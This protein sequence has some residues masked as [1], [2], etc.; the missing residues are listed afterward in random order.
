MRNLEALGKEVSLLSLGSD[1]QNPEPERVFAEKFKPR[2]FN[3]LE[4]QNLS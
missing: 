1:P 2:L 4:L 3:D